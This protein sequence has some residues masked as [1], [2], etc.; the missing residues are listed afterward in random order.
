MGLTSACRA[1]DAFTIPISRFEIDLSRGV[2]DPEILMQALLC[3]L[4]ARP[5]VGGRA[6][7]TDQGLLLDAFITGQRIQV[8]DHLPREARTNCIRERNRDGSRAQAQ[9]TG[10]SAAPMRRRSARLAARHIVASQAPL[11]PR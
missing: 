2:I 8:L 10:T 1:F 6:G 9:G 3:R 7:D 5:R 11:T 4:H